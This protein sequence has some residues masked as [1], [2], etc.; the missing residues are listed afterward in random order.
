M[1]KQGTDKKKLELDKE[2][3][4]NLSTGDGSG[5]GQG[6]VAISIGCTIRTF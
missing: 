5:N 3:L 4:K 2:T 6:A 1:K